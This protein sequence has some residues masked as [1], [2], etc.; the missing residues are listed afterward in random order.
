[1]PKKPR[2]PV[3]ATLNDP[4]YRRRAAKGAL[5]RKDQ[6]DPWSKNAK[7]KKPTIEESAPTTLAEFYQVGD[8]AEVI[9]GPL[10]SVLD[11]AEK[12]SKNKGKP[13]QKKSV[14][15]PEGVISE[16]NGPADT[17]GITIDGEYHLCDEE[18]LRLITE[19][20]GHAFEDLRE[21]SYADTTSGIRIPISSEE[22]EILSKCASP[23]FKENMDEREQ[24]VARRMVSRG[25]LHRRKN[26][27]GVYFIGDNH[28]LTRF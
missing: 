5:E 27:E 20:F 17:I 16:P 22:Q 2:N 8:K 14:T 19:G 4:K 7:H 11:K 18:D 10:K 23:L 28:K 25:V 15:K 26:D 3:A 12:L 6:R 9:S 1:M 24:E 13:T 21:W